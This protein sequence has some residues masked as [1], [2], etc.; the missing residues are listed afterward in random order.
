MNAIARPGRMYIETLTQLLEEGFKRGI[1]SEFDYEPE[2]MHAEGLYIR[3][4]K[5]LPA[6]LIIVTK[7]HKQQ[8]VAISLKGTVTC[9]DQNGKRT[10]IG[11]GE[12]FVT[13]PGTQRAIYCH[14]EVEWA[15]I[16]AANTDNVEELESMIFCNNFTEFDA[17]LNDMRVAA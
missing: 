3:K 16:H 11:P 15:T 8:N 4:T 5:T 13:E 12:L 9:F 10:V 14:D 2:H 1:F 17:L 7:V 6:G